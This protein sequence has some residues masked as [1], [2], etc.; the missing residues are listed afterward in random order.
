MQGVLRHR[1][2]LLRATRQMPKVQFMPT[3][4]RSE[5]KEPEEQGGGRKVPQGFEKLLKRSKGNTN[6]TPR[7]EAKEEKEKEEKA[8]EEKEEVEQE[9]AAEREQEKKSKDQ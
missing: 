2:I 5:G 3:V 8:K 1:Q 4:F 7:Q 9:E 6:T